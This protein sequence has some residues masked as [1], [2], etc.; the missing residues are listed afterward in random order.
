M[1]DGGKFLIAFALNLALMAVDAGAEPEADG[2]SCSFAGWEM[3][4]EVCR[5]AKSTRVFKGD[6]GLTFRILPLKN[7]AYSCELSSELFSARS[8]IRL[9]QSESFSVDALIQLA[10]EYRLTFSREKERAVAMLELTVNPTECSTS[11]PGAILWIA[12]SRS[13]NVFAVHGQCSKTLMYVPLRVSDVCRGTLDVGYLS[14]ARSIS[15]LYDKPAK[16]FWSRRIQVESGIFTALV[17]DIRNRETDV[18]LD[19]NPD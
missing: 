5:N 15:E 3:S 11:D 7:S 4:G 9:T 12:G 6:I 1:L 19:A 10:Q 13:F 2:A 8:A 16:F 18:A 17:R 14:G